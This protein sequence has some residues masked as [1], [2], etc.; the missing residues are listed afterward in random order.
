MLSMR[1]R[2]AQ[3]V[4]GSSRR[5]TIMLAGNVDENHMVYC[6]RSA[7][8]RVI[9]RRASPPAARWPSAPLPT[10]PPTL[11]KPRGTLTGRFI[12]E[13]R[14]KLRVQEAGFRVQVLPVKQSP[15]LAR[16]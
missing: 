13:S 6:A 11:G 2:L 8:S 1:F 7:N 16:G 5:I 15:P 3:A 4:K 14:E 10:S 9:N 12:A